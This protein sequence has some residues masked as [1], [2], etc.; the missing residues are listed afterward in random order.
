MGK[1]PL[2]SSGRRK[3]KNDHYLAGFL[4]LAIIL[5]ITPIKLMKS[6]R[7]DDIPGARPTVRQMPIN[8][9]RGK[10]EQPT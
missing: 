7:T 3:A 5:I 4:P 9:L 2:Y 6:L 8:L 10:R 1:M